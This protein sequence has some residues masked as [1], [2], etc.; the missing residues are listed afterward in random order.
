MMLEAIKIFFEERIAPGGRDAHRDQQHRLRVAVAALLAEVV[1][2]DE[3]ITEVERA[4]VLASI[5][6]KF[7][8]DATEAAELIALA[9]EEAL[10]ATDL[11]QFTSRINRAYDPSEKVRLIEHLWRV[12]YADGTLHR[13]EDHLIRKVAELLHVPHREFIATKLRVQGGS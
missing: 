12:A 6:G 8:L 3:E 5:A 9:E 7:D 4:Q 1:R 11:Y 13:Y 10:A 2:M